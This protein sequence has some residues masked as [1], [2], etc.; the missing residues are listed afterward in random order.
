MFCCVLLYVIYHFTSFSGLEDYKMMIDYAMYVLTD[1][2]GQPWLWYF[3]HFLR[4]QNGS[5]WLVNA[6]FQRNHDLLDGWE[7]L[8]NSE[9]LPFE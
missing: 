3:D 7:T 9:R 6:P 8:S 5:E 2:P 1:K 4:L